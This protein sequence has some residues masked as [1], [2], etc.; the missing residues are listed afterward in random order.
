MYLHSKYIFS[1]TR[2]LLV[3]WN[4]TNQHNNDGNRYNI[5]N[6]LNIPKKIRKFTD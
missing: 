6:I 1:K 5:S 4:D 2:N 3:N